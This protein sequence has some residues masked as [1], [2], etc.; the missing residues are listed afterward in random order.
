MI[1]DGLA[2]FAAGRHAGSDGGV[3]VYAAEPA[4]GKI[5]WHSN[6]EGYQTLPDL[7]VASGNGVHMADWQFDAR[8]GKDRSST[9]SQ[10]LR[11]ARLGLLNDAWYK[12]PIALRKNLQR[13][14]T[15]Q[16]SGQLLTFSK[17]WICGFRGPTWD[18]SGDYG[19]VSGYTQLFAQPRNGDGRGWSTNLPLGTNIKSLVLA[20]G[21]LFVAGRLNGYDVKSHGVRVLSAHDGKQLAE[22]HLGDPL[23]HECLSVA[24]GRVYLTTQG[25][26]VICLGEQ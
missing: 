8:T 14:S 16:T 20:E 3:H 17:K 10:F 6:P 11:S 26:R 5:V 23:V 2:Y 24:G 4:S 22:V 12:R 13:W 15:G 21:T 1:H 18:T 19:K 25:G 7:L 9:S